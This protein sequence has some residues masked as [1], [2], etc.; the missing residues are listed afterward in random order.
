MSSAEAARPISSSATPSSGT[1]L[2]SP[3]SG[4][5]ATSPISASRQ[6]VRLDRPGS[7]RPTSGIAINAPTAGASS[8]EPELTG[9]RTDTIGERGDPRCPRR[10]QRAVDKEHCRDRRPGAHRH[11][12]ATGLHGLCIETLLVSRPAHCGRLATRQRMAAMSRQEVYDYIVIGA[13]SAGC[14]AAGRLSEDPHV[15][16]AV[17]EAGPPVGEAVRCTGAVRAPAQVRVR[18]G[19]PD[20]AGAR[21]R[22]T[23]ELSAAR[24]R[25]RRHKRDEHDAL[26]PRQ[27]RATMTRGPPAMRRAGATR[28]CC[29]SSCAR[30]T[31]SAVRAYSTA[32]AGRSR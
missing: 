21:A 16:V 28:T 11:A 15:R 30:R 6:N 4:I 9:R 29:R 26:R 8:R 12:A 1:L 7:M 17:I 3:G 2:A 25:R 5:V 27:R 31:T 23:A 13:G 18:L 14:A 22:W 24:P 32:P 19:L 10:K 20:R